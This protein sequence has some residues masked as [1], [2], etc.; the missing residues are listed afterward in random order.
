MLNNSFPACCNFLKQL[1]SRGKEIKAVFYLEYSAKIIVTPEC[2]MR[3]ANSGVN[4]IKWMGYMEKW[5]PTPRY[6][7]HDNPSAQGTKVICF[8]AGG[9]YSAW[10]A[11]LHYSNA[12]LCH[13]DWA[14]SRY[15]PLVPA[16]FS[17]PPVSSIRAHWSVPEG[18][19]KEAYLHLK[20]KKRRVEDRWMT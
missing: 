9:L 15:L 14:L 1:R 19:Y 20:W 11:G 4:G 13:W 12:Q 10:S 5:P 3:E 18:N 2:F 7:R 16:C 6:R 8:T 17:S